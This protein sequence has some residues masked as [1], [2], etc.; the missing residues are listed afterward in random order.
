MWVFTVFIG[1]LKMHEVKWFYLL[2][3][4][5]HFIS[6]K[7]VPLAYG[8]KKLQICCVVEDDKVGGS[9]IVIILSVVNC[10]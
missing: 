3:F 7:L 5:Y 4:Y 10:Q 1:N 6:A 2:S 9:S 8:I